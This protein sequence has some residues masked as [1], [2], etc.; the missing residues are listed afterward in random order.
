MQSAVLRDGWTGGRSQGRC[1][2]A[3]CGGLR[4]AVARSRAQLLRQL[5]A[6]P[7]VVA[8]AAAAVEV[9]QV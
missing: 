2:G 7:W 4:G 3:G 5:L 9:I 6:V 8:G 1:Q